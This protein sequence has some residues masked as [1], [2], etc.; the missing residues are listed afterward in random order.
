MSII[1][2]F[3][4][5]ELSGWKAWEAITLFAS[6]AIIVAL[7]LY[8]HD[9]LMGIISAATGVAYTVCN[10]KGKR[11]AYVFGVVN[12]ALYA[13]IAFNARIYGD[14]ALYGLYYLPAMIIGFVLWSR[15]MSSENLEVIK[16]SM[17][18][19]ER[20]A[21]LLGCVVAVLA[22]GFVLRA[23]GDAVPFLDSFTTVVSLIAMLVAL[24]RY[25]E[26]WPLWTAVNAIEVLLWTTRLAQGGAAEAGSSLIMWTLFL[27]I[28]I[29]MWARWN[30]QI[31]TDIAGEKKGLSEQKRVL[32]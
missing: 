17:K 16:R 7:S 29:V 28:G 24:G 30:H 22:G 4:K 10:G 18:F 14:A 1:L 23:M 13:I 31:K 26:Q 27:I 32:P 20:I 25:Q 9:S 8:W 6:L 2:S 15:H 21:L 19:W 3:L 12:S 11:L 5:E